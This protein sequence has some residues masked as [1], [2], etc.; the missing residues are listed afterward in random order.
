ME[1]KL[2]WYV[3]FVK[4]CQD[5]KVAQSLTDLGV[6]H[7]YAVM[8]VRKKRTDRI[9]IK[10]SRII[11]GRIFI[12]TTPSRR[13]PLLSEIYGLY[14]YMANGVG[15]P[16]VIPDE[17]MNVFMDVVNKSNEAVEFHQEHIKPGDK[18][19]VINGPLIGLECELIEINGRNY[20]KMKLGQVGCLLTSIPLEYVEKIV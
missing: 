2:H 18:V 4:S 7:F 14:A 9:V 17:Q 3:G 19:R 16:V 15:N 1:Q 11:P 13:V 20:A 5:A 6:E 8:K 10:E 12:R